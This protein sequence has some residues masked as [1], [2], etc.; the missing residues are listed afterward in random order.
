MSQDIQ[1][2]KPFWLS[3]QC[4]GFVYFFKH[5]GLE[6][7]ALVDEKEII[8]YRQSAKDLIENLEGNECIAFLE[9]LRDECAQRVLEWEKLR[10]KQPEQSG[11]SG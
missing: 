1:H 8:D 3:R 9:A 7:V 10:E 5:C 11:I 2:K 4:C 6:I